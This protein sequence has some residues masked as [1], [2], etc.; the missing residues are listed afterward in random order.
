MNFLTN[1]AWKEFITSTSNEIVEYLCE[2]NYDKVPMV[3]NRVN[4][5]LLKDLELIEDI[6]IID[7]ETSNMKSCCAHDIFRISFELIYDNVEEQIIEIMNNKYN[8]KTF[9]QIHDILLLVKSIETNNK[10]ITIDYVR[11][12][13]D[14]VENLTVE[15]LKN[16]K[17]IDEKIN[18]LKDTIGKIEKG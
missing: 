13:I 4:K 12:D 18:Y 14:S 9:C 5:E 15:N 16:R 8:I 6:V 2:L 1:V 10:W 11:G 3:T 7:E 17:L